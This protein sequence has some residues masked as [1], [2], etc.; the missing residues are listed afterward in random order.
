MREQERELQTLKAALGKV[1]DNKVA[2]DTLETKIKDMEKKLDKEGSRY[3]ELKRQVQGLNLNPV[4]MLGR[5]VGRESPAAK[6][7][8]IKELWLKDHEIA[9]FDNV[10]YYKK[11]GQS[12]L[13]AYVKKVNAVAVDAEVVVLGANA[14]ERPEDINDDHVMVVFAGVTHRHLEVRHAHTRVDVMVDE[15]GLSASVIIIVT[16]IGHS[17]VAVET[18]VQ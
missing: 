14:D 3:E 17:S 15:I 18:Y 4:D 16:V 11:K 1:S 9:K 7:A 2:S 13:S 8:R 10:D 12:A 5:A 6:K